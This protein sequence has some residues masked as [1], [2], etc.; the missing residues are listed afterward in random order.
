M[1]PEA[2]YPLTAYN[3]RVTVGDAELSF[4]EVSGLAVE[5]EKVTY[6]H[7]LSFREGETIT[8]HLF[9]KFVALTLKRGVVHGENPLY[10]WLLD[11]E[12]RKMAISLCNAEGD[13]VVTWDI[14]RAV[15]IKLQGPSLKASGNEVAIETLDLQ[16][17][18]VTVIHH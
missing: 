11:N 10:E 6:R 13:P 3:Y 18:G 9:E 17:S 1:D 5:Y 15:A 8:K 12:P 16:V 14:R 2:R 4:S 7:G